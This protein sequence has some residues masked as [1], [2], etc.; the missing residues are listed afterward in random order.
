MLVSARATGCKYLTTAAYVFHSTVEAKAGVAANPASHGELFFI[1][2]HRVLAVSVVK[3]VIPGR[4]ILCVR[5]RRPD[6]GA[7]LDKEKRRSASGGCRRRGDGSGEGFPLAGCRVNEFVL[8]AQVPPI[9]PPA[10]PARRHR[11]VDD[12]SRVRRLQR[13]I[14]LPSRLLHHRLRLPRRSGPRSNQ[15]AGP[16]IWGHFKAQVSEPTV[17]RSGNAMS[18]AMSAWRTTLT[19][20][21]LISAKGLMAANSARLVQPVATSTL[22]PALAPA[23]SGNIRTRSASAPTS[24]PPLKRKGQMLMREAACS[25]R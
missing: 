24:T 8:L 1:P 7:H 21:Q 25:I 14:N 18:N 17:T 20:L 6:G 10:E 2:A 12:Q 22:M 9:H 4:A 15:A 5:K 11:R 19:G 3:G 13:R 23:P 16:K